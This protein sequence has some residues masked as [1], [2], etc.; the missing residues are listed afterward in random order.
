MRASMAP[1]PLPVANFTERSLEPPLS[2]AVVR[3]GYVG[4]CV[5]DRI[6]PPLCFKFTAF[7]LF[8]QAVMGILY[9]ALV[10]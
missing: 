5:F 2:F 10:I 7:H 4:A 1:S 8:F 6:L 9:A 3:A